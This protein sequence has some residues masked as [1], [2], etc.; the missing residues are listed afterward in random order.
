MIVIQPQYVHRSSQ[1]GRCTYNEIGAAGSDAAAWSRPVYAGASKESV[2]STAVGYEVYRGPGRSYCC[3]R[4]AAPEPDLAALPVADEGRDVMRQRQHKRRAARGRPTP[5]RK[6]AQFFTAIGRTAGAII[7]L[8]DS[9]H[10][11]S[12][13]AAPFR[14]A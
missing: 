4:A 1:K 5:G 6:P 9:R 11:R 14:I 10:V 12:N 7:G 3:S 2:N 8:P 13:R